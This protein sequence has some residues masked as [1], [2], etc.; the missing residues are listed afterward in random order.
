MI[1]EK[2]RNVL[3]TGGAGFIGSHIC[4]YLLRKGYNVIC[5]DNLVTGRKKNLS[6]IKSSNFKFLE[7]DV[8]KPI[9]IQEENVDYVLHLASPASPVDYHQM[10][11]ETLLTGAMGTLNTLNLSK[12][13]GAVYL[14]A[15]TSEVYGDPKVNPQ[16]EEYWGNVN[17]IGVRSCYD[18]S[19]RFAEALTIAYHRVHGVD[20]RIVRIFNT[21]GPRMRVDDG[22]AVPT[23]ITQALRGQPITIHGT[24]NQTRSFCYVD[25]LVEGIYLAMTNPACSGQPINL[26]NPEEITILELAGLINKL[27]GNKSKIVHGPPMPDDPKQRRPDITKARKLLGWT[28]STPLEE[29]LRKTIEWFK[30]ELE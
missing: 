4:E 27:C 23:F 13:H 1:K 15:S 25:D 2:D 17:P 10:P 9:K 21:Y 24:G 11:I 8:T 3:V 29:G 5:I 14:L 22:R 28:P 20:T 16:P 19:K 26:G 18:E 7:L 12:E 6:M 30:E